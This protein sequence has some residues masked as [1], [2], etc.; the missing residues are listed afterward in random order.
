M[1]WTERMTRRVERQLA[2]WMRHWDEDGVR[3][4]LQRLRQLKEYLKDRRARGEL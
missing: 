3:G 1:T 2:V 4:V